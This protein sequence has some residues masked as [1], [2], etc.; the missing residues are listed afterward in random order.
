[1]VL[2]PYWQISPSIGER[3]QQIKKT[4]FF[5]MVFSPFTRDTLIII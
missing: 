5:G 4:G 2:L 1:M 3:M